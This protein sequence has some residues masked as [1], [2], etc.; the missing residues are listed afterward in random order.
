MKALVVA[1]MGHEPAIFSANI[2]AKFE[3]FN[4]CKDILYLLADTKPMKGLN[5]IGRNCIKIMMFFSNPP[6]RAGL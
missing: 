3:S 4:L 5:R 6:I 1:V 2:M